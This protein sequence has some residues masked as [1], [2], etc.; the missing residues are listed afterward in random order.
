MDFSNIQALSFD[1]YGTIVD[2]EAGILN[3]LIPWAERHRLNATPAE[4]LEAFGSVETKIQMENPDL[5]YRAVL[6]E[7]ANRISDTFNVDRAE[8]F[9][10]TLGNSIG[11]WPAFPDSREALDQLGQRFKLV[12]LSNIDEEAFAET[13]RLQLNVSFDH[14]LTAETIG[15]YKPDLN[16]FR[17]LIDHLGQDG[18]EDNKLAHVAQSLYHDIEPASKIGLQNIWI[19]RRGNNKGFGATPPPSSHVS[20]DLQ[21]PSLIDLANHIEYALG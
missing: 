15:T 11:Q 20:P 14:I 6:R 4:L 2:W 10:S 19:D 12:I 21:F 7:V 9:S 3:V 18:I 16:N 8:S 1:C 5:K 13:N 17:Y